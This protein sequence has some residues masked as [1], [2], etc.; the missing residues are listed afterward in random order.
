MY[1]C[2]FFTPFLKK[3]YNMKKNI[4]RWA[5]CLTILL[6]VTSGM[7]QTKVTLTFQNAS[8]QEIEVSASGKIY[9]SDNY[10]YIDDGTA[11]PYSFAVSDIRNMQFEQVV[12]IQDIETES[13]RIYPNPVHNELYISGN[14]FRPIAYQI[15]SMDG[16]LLLQGETNEGNPIFVG[17]L[18]TGICILKIH[19]SSFKI[20]K[21]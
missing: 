14:D 5:M 17:S 8:T 21:L 15:F 11:V 6:W 7:A 18:P 3:I 1:L 12:G 13:F 16:R 4:Q 20:S 19:N 10:M 9:F 2:I